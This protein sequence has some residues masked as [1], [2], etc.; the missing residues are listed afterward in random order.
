MLSL[1]LFLAHLL[2]ALQLLV[3]FVFVL[4]LNLTHIVDS[5]CM[6]VILNLDA[7]TLHPKLDLLFEL[8]LIHFGLNFAHFFFNLKLFLVLLGFSQKHAIVVVVHLWVVRALVHP[9]L[10]S[11]AVAVV[12]GAIFIE[13]LSWGRHRI[14][15]FLEGTKVGS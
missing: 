6:L 1:D 12:V 15:H 7:L 11:T 13:L 4:L 2:E 8:T 9:D 3:L 10:G 5:V 14:A